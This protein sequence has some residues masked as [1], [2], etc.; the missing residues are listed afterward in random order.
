[1]SKINKKCT[2]CPKKAKRLSD[3]FG[4]QTCNKHLRIKLAEG[5]L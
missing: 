2:F 5:G 4:Y 3:Y 1:M